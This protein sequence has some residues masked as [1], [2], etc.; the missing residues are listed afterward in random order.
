MADQPIEVVRRAIE[1][2]GRGDVEGFIA[3]FAPDCEVTFRPDVPEPGPFHGPDQLR[4]WAEGF[5]QAWESQSLEILTSD[6]SGDDVFVVLR[7]TSHG[8]GSG[9][10]NVAD[11]AFVFT[12]RDGLI[13]RWRGFVEQDEARAAA[14]LST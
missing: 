9:I 14:G 1:A 10:D 2:W 4:G 8:A 3:M 11:F 12:V 7:L 13:A 6:A 5:R